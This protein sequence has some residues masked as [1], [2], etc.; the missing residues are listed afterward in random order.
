MAT[1]QRSPSVEL[2]PVGPS[3]LVRTA[4]AEHDLE[5]VAQ[6][7]AHPLGDEDL[8]A[9]PLQPSDLRGIAD[10]H[11]PAVVR[12]GLP[13]QP[14]AVEGVADLVGLFHEGLVEIALGHPV[15]ILV[16]GEEHSS[17]GQHLAQRDPVRPVHPEGAG[18]GQAEVLGRQAHA[19]H[20]VVERA[21]LVGPGRGRRGHECQEEGEGRKDPSEGSEHGSTPWAM[22]PTGAVV[23]RQGKV[24]QARRVVRCRPMGGYSQPYARLAARGDRLVLP[25]PFD[26]PSLFRSFHRPAP[27]GDR[28][29]RRRGLGRVRRRR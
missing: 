12:P 21:P 20:G 26:L 7:P 8:P 28:R 16:E 27:S 29:P 1:R 5:A 15:E 25:V 10:Q 9:H 13:H 18:G 14:E 4:P 19:V 22:A 24:A 2:E 23:A 6:G 11:G 3:A 17:D